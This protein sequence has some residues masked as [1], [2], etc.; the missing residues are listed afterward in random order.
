[1]LFWG[2]RT[3]RSRRARKG[4]KGRKKGRK[5]RTKKVHPPSVISLTPLGGATIPPTTGVLN[6]PQ[7]YVVYPT[8]TLTPGGGSGTKGIRAKKPRK[9]RKK[10]GKKKKG[11][12]GK[13][14][15]IFSWGKT[16]S[17]FIW[18]K[19][20]SPFLWGSIANPFGF[21]TPKAIGKKKKKGR[22]GRK[23]KKGRKGRKKKPTP[24]I[25][26]TPRG[27][28]TANAKK[29]VNTSLAP[30]PLK[31]KPGDVFNPQNNLFHHARQHLRREHFRFRT[32]LISSHRSARL[33]NRKFRMRDSG[34]PRKRKQKRI[35]V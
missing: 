2:G 30:A 1:M 4:K 20:G 28:F 6:L 21:T 17:P 31:V 22:K 8:I 25:E 23:G 18:G 16:G 10:K 3:P 14:G 33:G 15:G 24:L 29:L 13:K 32:N 5:Y 7:P 11:R 9:K 19:T 26:L 34:L 12:K 35:K 27:G